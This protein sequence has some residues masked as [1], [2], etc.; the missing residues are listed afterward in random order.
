[1]AFGVF[2]PYLKVSFFISSG[3]VYLNFK[4]VK[5]LRLV[6]RVSI[7]LLFNLLLFEVLS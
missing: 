2:L 1:M 7:L 6:N 4:N 5:L 3:F